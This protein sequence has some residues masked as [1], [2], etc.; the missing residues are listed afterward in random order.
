[1]STQRIFAN[2]FSTL[3]EAC[4]CK[5]CST[6]LSRKCEFK[7][8]R[9]GRILQPSDLNEHS[10]WT[11]GQTVLFCWSK[12][13][14]ASDASYSLNWKA[15]A[16]SLV[17]L[18]FVELDLRVTAMSACNQSMITE[19]LVMVHF[20]T[21]QLCVA[22]CKWASLWSEFTDFVMSG[23]KRLSF[24]WIFEFPICMTLLC[25]EL[26]LDLKAP[27]QMERNE[28]SASSRM[29]ECNQSIRLPNPNIYAQMLFGWL[30][31]ADWTS[32]LSR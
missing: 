3:L 14:R 4:D 19:C 10:I 5:Q 18:I 24:A 23:P 1:M 26:T 22:T 2:V 32:R 28:I 6:A 31:T 7:S 16:H 13:P 29:I 8:R 27:F 11:S 30:A 20:T 25:I 9:S 17:H 12:S 21:N 15:C